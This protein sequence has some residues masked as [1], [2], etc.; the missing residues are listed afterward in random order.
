MCCLRKHLPALWL[1]KCVFVDR[2]LPDMKIN[3]KFLAD[4]VCSPVR[5]DFHQK[6]H[7]SKIITPPGHNI[8]PWKGEFL[9][10]SKLIQGF[11]LP[12]LSLRHATWLP[13]FSEIFPGFPE[14]AVSKLFW[15]L[16]LSHYLNREEPLQCTRYVSCYPWSTVGWC[17]STQK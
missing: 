14:R 17:F 7:E 6:T 11:A 10:K 1:T 15:D 4:V 13:R 5:F 9:N 16:F 12:R 3:I 8:Q 2:I